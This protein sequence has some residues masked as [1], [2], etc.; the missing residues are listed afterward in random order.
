MSVTEGAA[1]SGVVVHQDVVDTKHIGW[2]LFPWKICETRFGTTVDLL[3]VAATV[4]V[5]IFF[6]F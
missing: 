4:M 6:A 1:A 5:V 2:Y 3:V